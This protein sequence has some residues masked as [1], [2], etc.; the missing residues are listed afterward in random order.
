MACLE[1]SCLRSCR[2]RT[3]STSVGRAYVNWVFYG[4]AVCLSFCIARMVYMTGPAFTDM[5]SALTIVVFHVFAFY[6][7]MRLNRCSNTGLS[8]TLTCAPMRIPV[9]VRH[10]HPPLHAAA[11]NERPSTAARLRMPTHPCAFGFL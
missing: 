7:P 4:R 8:L 5:Q 3:P 6:A 11:T 1:L 9:L 2:Y 10:D